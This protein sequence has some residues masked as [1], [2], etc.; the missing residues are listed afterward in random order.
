MPSRVGGSQPAQPFLCGSRGCLSLRSAAWFLQQHFSSSTAAGASSCHRLSHLSPWAT[1]LRPP[2]LHM[3]LPGH[4]SALSIP[5]AAETCWSCSPGASV[6]PPVKQYSPLQTRMAARGE[7]DGQVGGWFHGS[8]HLKAAKAAQDSHPWLIQGPS[9]PGWPQGCRAAR[10]WVHVAPTKAP[11]YLEC[12]EVGVQPSTPQQQHGAGFQ[13]HLPQHLVN[14]HLTAWHQAGAS[15]LSQLH[16]ATVPV[17]QQALL[18]IHHIVVRGSLKSRAGGHQAASP[19]P[20]TPGCPPVPAAP[21]Q[22]PGAHH[23]HGHAWGSGG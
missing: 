10:F 3:T 11:R 9:P 7:G 18:L 22:M 15:L 13:H 21:S 20:P 14:Y 6:S 16:A 5:H 19:L 12:T 1:A 8:L 23:I 17:K 2:C 4:R